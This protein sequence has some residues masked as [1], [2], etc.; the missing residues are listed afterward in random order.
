MTAQVVTTT[1]KTTSTVKKITW[2]WL[3]TDGGV[4]SSAT[5]NRYDGELIAAVFFPDPIT[6]TPTT[7]YDVTI[8][9][10]DSVDILNGL[11]ADLAV[12]GAVTKKHTDGLGAVA[13]SVLTLT[14][15]NAGNAKGGIVYLYIR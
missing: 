9:D 8:L 14:I 4:V 5:T 13:D 1:E 7:L 12:T 6:T 2:D 10:S 3:C 11:G 15:A